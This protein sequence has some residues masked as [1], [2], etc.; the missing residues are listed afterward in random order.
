MSDL[1]AK[2]ERSPKA[3]NKTMLLISPI[4]LS[5]KYEFVQKDFNSLNP[6]RSAE[7]TRNWN[8]TTANNISNDAQLEN[9]QLPVQY[10]SYE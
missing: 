9:R 5:L 10:G 1:V 4:F 6:Y 8:L 2:A 3:Q 7:F